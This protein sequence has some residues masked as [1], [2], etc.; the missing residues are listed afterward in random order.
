[1]T[2]NHH[3]GHCHARRPK[4]A[5][6]CRAFS[7]CAGAGRKSV[8]VPKGRAVKDIPILR[9]NGANDTNTTE[10]GGNTTY[11]GTAL[12]QAI[13]DPP[14]MYRANL[15]MHNTYRAKHAD[16]PALAWD[17][18]IADAAAAYASRCV[19]GHDPN[20]KQWG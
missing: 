13:T 8:K 14:A 7:S 18:T 20:N 12:I 4:I 9:M 3:G 11:Q 16:T 1:V 17:D 5:A 15:D 10:P 2:N 19:W 6:P